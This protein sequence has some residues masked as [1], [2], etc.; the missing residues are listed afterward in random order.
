[1]PYTTHPLRTVYKRAGVGLNLLLQQMPADEQFAVCQTEEVRNRV[2]EAQAEADLKYQG[3]PFTWKMM[4]GDLANM[5]DALPYNAID[6]G[7]KWLC[8][9][10]REWTWKRHD[11]DVSVSKW[12]REARMG[13]NTADDG[14]WVAFSLTELQD[15]CGFDNKNSLVLLKGVVSQQCA[16]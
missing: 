10:T 4:V 6:E 13:K 3:R 2:W 11:R 7:I 16:G 8:D 14:L 9:S 1:M 15:I 12:G 5:Y